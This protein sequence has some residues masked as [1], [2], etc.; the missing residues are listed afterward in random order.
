[1]AKQQHYDLMTAKEAADWLRYSER[2]LRVARSTGELGGTTAP[3]FIK[4]GRHVLYRHAD[5]V[6]WM[7][8]FAIV[9]NTA[10]AAQ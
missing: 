9:T 5:L 2:T 8:Q 6:Q 3:P 10:Q 7:N 1:M 4:R